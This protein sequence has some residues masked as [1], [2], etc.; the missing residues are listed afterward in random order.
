MA[1]PQAAIAHPASAAS[2]A[3]KVACACWYWNEC[4]PSMPW[5]KRRWHSGDP[6]TGKSSWPSAGAAGWGALAPNAAGAVARRSRRAPRKRDVAF[7]MRSSILPRGA[8]CARNRRQHDPRAPLSICYKSRCE[9]RA[10]IEESPTARRGARERP[11]DTGRLRM[12]AITRIDVRLKTGDL[13]GTD[14]DVYI[15]IG[16]REFYIDS[17]ND[18]FERNSDR[19]YT[20]GEGA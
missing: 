7:F 19:T 3:W 16:G 17:E 18:D 8:E 13:S 2:A 6:V 4:I 15:R 12:A 11:E 5:R 9:S 14:G 20:L 10:T 1:S